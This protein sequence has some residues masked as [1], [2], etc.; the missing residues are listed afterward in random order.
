MSPFTISIQ[1]IKLYFIIQ[2]Q[3]VVLLHCCPFSANLFIKNS[4]HVQKEFCN[5]N[6]VN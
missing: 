4:S 6:V 5:K 2:Q 3:K 1:Y